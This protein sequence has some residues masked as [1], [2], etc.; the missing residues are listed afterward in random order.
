MEAA[1]QDTIEVLDDEWT[2]RTLAELTA[3]EEESYPWDIAA[4]TGASIRAEREAIARG[5]DEVIMRARLITAK[6]RLRQGDVAS[7]SRTAWQINSW[8][9]EHYCRPVRCRTH[10]VL[11]WCYYVL[12]DPAACLEHAVLAVE[13]TDEH[14]SSHA[15]ITHLVKLADALWLNGSYD[16]ARERYRQAE[17]L[18]VADRNVNLHMLCLNNLAYG[19]LSS[20]YAD[21]AWVVAQRLLSTAG[22]YGYEPDPN[23]LDTIAQIQIATGRYAEAEQ[24]MRQCMTRHRDGYHEEPDALAEYLLTLASAQRGQGAVDRAQTTL[25]RSM[26]LCEERDLGD[27]RTRV[28][29]E[30][31]ELYAACGDHVRA[32]AAHKAFFAAHERMR[33]QQREAQAQNRL[34]MFETAEARQEAERFRE[35]ARRDPLTGLRN[36]RYVDENLPGLLAAGTPVTV[37]LID[38][39][40]F[41]RINDTLS[42]EIGD[43]VLVNVAKVLEAGVPAAVP[44]GFAARLGGE[45]FLL[46]LPGLEVPAAHPVVERVRLDV[47]SYPWQPVTGDLPVTV[48]IGM[49][50]S[51]GVDEPDQAALLSVADRHLYAA[52]H[53]GR[54]RVVTGVDPGT[55]RRRYRDAR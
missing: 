40:H 8:A 49:A 12:G 3:L 55:G 25:D 30:Q 18:A 42:H 19:E 16:A 43:A 6:M 54:D 35:Q 37:A 33:S 21:R 27:L 52:K 39:D 31:A 7:A 53:A 47:R 10:L 48:S 22:T 44:G 34:A 32:Y 4:I 26:A 28:M 50:G 1:G 51:V 9:V 29:Q 17:A 36:R 45:E 38:L 14:E 20:G 23:D 41:K 15:R 24:T 5:A 46:V 13:H 2:R 11:A